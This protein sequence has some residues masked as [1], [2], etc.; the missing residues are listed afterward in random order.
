M[1]CEVPQQQEGQLRLIRLDVALI[2]DPLRADRTESRTLWIDGSKFVAKPADSR[3]VEHHYRM[4][5]CVAMACGIDAHTHIGG[6][7]VNLA[8]LMLSGRERSEIV[9]IEE[10]LPSQSRLPMRPLSC[11]VPNTL[12]TGIRYLEMGYSAC[13]EPAVLPAGARHA[14][15]ELADTPF[16]DTGGFLMLGNELLL[17]KMISDGAPA[18]QI[19]DYVA[20]MLNAHRCIAVKVV[21]AVG[22]SRF[23]ESSPFHDHVAL[24]SIDDP[25]PRF[26]VSGRRVLL[27]LARAVDSLGIPHP[28]HVHCANLGL[29]GNIETTLE[30]IRAVEGHRM[31]LTHAQFHCYGKEGPHGFGSA[32]SQLADEVNKNPKL[33][34]DVGQVL[35]G[36]TITLS[37]DLEHQW[38]HR[39]LGRPRKGAFQMIE[40]QGGCGVL[41]FR[42]RQ[43][44]YVHSLQWAIGLELFLR[45][46]NPWQI[47][48]TTD[49]PNG[50]PFTAYPHIVRLLCD[51]DFR[52]HCFEHLHPD[53]RSTSSL[54]SL[55][56]EYTLD[57]IAIVTRSAPARSLGL[58]QY[59]SLEAGSVA[60]LCLFQQNANK[61][62]MFVQP[63]WVIRNGRIAVQDGNVKEEVPKTSFQIQLPLNTEIERFMAKDWKLFY[64]QSPALSKISEDEAR[65]L[66]AE[67]W[68]LEPT[69]S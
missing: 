34:V 65:L 10:D 59:G 12:E 61:E 67:I 41:P 19:R 55:P 7:K 15:C 58:Q 45:I 48:L 25:H 28:I 23:K 31:H 68:H 6:G 47:F 56:R 33:S 52:Q 13:F 24:G 9:S 11:P 29:P 50:A 38:S 69:I 8:R 4:L 26:G 62:A 42:Y 53:V 63:K 39:H 44:Q 46:E 64:Q 40:N 49:H 3:Q 43:A 18:T 66:R 16:L 35:F 20:W 27:E 51:A 5:D 36:Q 22:V 30:T 32:A 14:H 1:A 54:P 57:E 17:L 60:N 37:G 21:H 2:C